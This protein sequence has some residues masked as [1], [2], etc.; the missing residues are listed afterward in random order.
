MIGDKYNVTALCSLQEF[1]PEHVNVSFTTTCGSFHYLN[2]TLPIR[3]ADGTY[4][5]THRFLM[6]ITNCDSTITGTC[7]T[8]HQTG[9]L[10][11]SAKLIIEGKS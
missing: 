7:V 11:I 3:N 4:N 8:E 9:G 10:N 2:N 5:T 1:Y 6:N